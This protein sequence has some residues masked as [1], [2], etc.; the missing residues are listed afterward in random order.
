MSTSNPFDKLNVRREE[1]EDDQ[2]EFEQVKGKEKNIPYGTF[3]SLL[4][5][6]SNSP[7]SSSSSSLRIFNLSNGLLVDILI[8]YFLF[9]A[10]K[11]MRKIIIFN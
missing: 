3:F 4:F 11:I 5:T 9:G 6:C 2:G 1:E 10:L 8:K 7:W